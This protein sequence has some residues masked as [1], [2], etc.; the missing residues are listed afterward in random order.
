[1]CSELCG[2]SH[3]GMPIHI[4]AL[5]KADFAKWVVKA[6]EEFADNSSTDKS[7]PIRLANA[8]AGLMN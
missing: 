1:M 6:K 3:S 4:K 2:V 5:S 7:Q 8:S